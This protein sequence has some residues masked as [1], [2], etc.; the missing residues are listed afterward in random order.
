[1][2]ARKLYPGDPRAEEAALV[3]VQLDVLCSSDP[4]FK[5]QLEFFADLAAEKRR[6]AGSSRRRS[7]GKKKRKT[8]KKRETHADPLEDIEAFLKKLYE[9][10]QMSKML[11]SDTALI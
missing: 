4:I 10:R 2:I 8:Q 5:K 3:H 11:F 6:N 7:P 1:M 9:I